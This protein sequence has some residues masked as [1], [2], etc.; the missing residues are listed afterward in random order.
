MSVDAEE[1]VGKP[2]GSLHPHDVR[3]DRRRAVVSQLDWTF[4]DMKLEYG[5]LR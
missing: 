2:F 1:D 3:V 5:E 4:K